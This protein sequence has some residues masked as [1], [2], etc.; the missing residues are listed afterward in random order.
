MHLELE[1]LGLPLLRDDLERKGQWL[2]QFVN[3]T[4]ETFLGCGNSQNGFAWLECMHCPSSHKLIPFSC[5]IRG[6]CIE[7]C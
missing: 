7:Y 1:Q 5:G 4:F 2:P 6:F 3:R